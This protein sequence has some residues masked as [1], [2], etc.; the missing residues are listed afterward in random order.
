M[1]PD[2]KQDCDVQTGIHIFWDNSNLYYSALNAV[3]P[4]HERFADPRALRLHMDHLVDLVRVGRPIVRAVAVGSRLERIRPHFDRVGIAVETYEVGTETG[5][6]QGV[7]Q[8]L[9][10]HMLR[11]ALDSPPG[12]AVLL[13]GDGKGSTEGVGFLADFQR[14]RRRGWSVELLAWRRTCNVELR[15]WAASE[16]TFTDL[17]DYYSEIT[18]LE[19]ERVAKPLKVRNRTV[20]RHPAASSGVAPPG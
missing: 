1:R 5:R 10:V 17:E 7:D 11:A 15:E 19:N 20:V 8:C 2:A 4:H 12:I 6:E 18:F 16:G 9:Q 13:T 14:M 3:A